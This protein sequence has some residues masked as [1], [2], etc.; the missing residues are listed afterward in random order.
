[1]AYLV[2]ITSRAERDL[3]W[4]YEE[5]NVEYS[6][7]ALKWY[8]GLKQAILSLEEKPTRCPITR[9]RDRLRQLF[10]GRKPHVYRVLFVIKDK[11]VNILHIRHGRR[12]PLSG[13]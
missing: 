12:R 3:T 7:A 10:Y 8:S 6:T 5:I 13:H 9:K 1:M 2:N 11:T 4:L